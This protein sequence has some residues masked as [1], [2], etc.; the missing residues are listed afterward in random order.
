MGDVMPTEVPAGPGTR[1]PLRHPMSWVAMALA[2]GSAAAFAVFYVFPYYV[3]DLN[4]FPLDEVA[5]G[6]PTDPWPFSV[7]GFVGHV[8]GLGAVLTM[9]FGPAVAA[10]AAGWAGFNLWRSRGT[11]DPRRTRLG[12]VTLAVS[13]VTWAWILSPQN[14]ALFTWILD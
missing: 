13:A 7:E 4:E 5:G 9:L 11:H 14:Q 3:N 2:V 8:F 6:L 12:V 10:I 1:T